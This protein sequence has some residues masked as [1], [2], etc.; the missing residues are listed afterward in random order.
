VT[1]GRAAFERAAGAYPL[2]G[3]PVPPGVEAIGRASLDETGLLLV[4]ERHGVEQTPR[5]ILSLV[6]TLRADALAFEWSW[7]EFDHVV[8]PVLATGRVDAEALWSLPDG[9]EAFSG[10][11]RFTAGHV[12]LLEALAPRLRQ[13]LLADR[14]VSASPQAREADMA[15]RLLRHRVRGGRML[16]VLGAAHATREQQGGVEPAGVLVARELPAVRTCMLAPAGGTVWHHGES[17][18]RSGWPVFDAELPIGEARPARV[19]VRPKHM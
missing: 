19:P 9:A 18:V 2:D 5:A 6:L 16:A 1:A 17:S 12:R 10:D 11:G 8:Q 4:G 15:E 3:V 13:V 14:L 7:D